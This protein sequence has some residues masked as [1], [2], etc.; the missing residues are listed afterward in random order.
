MTN[1]ERRWKETESDWAR[2]EMA[3]YFTDIPCAA[4]NGLP[5]QARGAVREG[6]RPPYRRGRR[7]VGQA[8]AANGS[9]RLPSGSRQAERD[10]GARAQGDPRAAQVPGRRGLEYLTL[11]RASGTLSG[12]ESQRIRLASQIGSGLTGVLY[13][14]DEP[15]IGLHQRDNARLLE[16]LKR[17]R[18]LGNTVIVVEHDEDAIRAADHVLDIGPGAGIH[19]G[20]IV[21]QGTIDDL[22]AT[23]DSLTG[24][25]LSGELT[26]RFQSAAPQTRAPHARRRQRARQQPQ[27]RHRRNPARP[28]HLRHRRVRRRQVDAPDRHALQGARAQ[29]QRRARE[30]PAPHDRIEG[31]EHLDKV[32]DIDQSPIGRTPRSN[33]AT[34]TG[35]FTP[36][37]ELVRAAARGARRAATSPAASPSTSRAGAAR[38]ARATA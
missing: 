23:P 10:R 12:G 20:H 14:L 1:L 28:V 15:S 19:G 37:R 2:E 25:Y 33:P 8:R 31:L 30:A 16:T 9:T 13:V 17:L 5:A 3:K 34:Y 4:C 21:A 36:I 27:E 29:A 18:D 35:A 24:K 6:R 22:I 38:P 11:A 7:N 26:V 32:I